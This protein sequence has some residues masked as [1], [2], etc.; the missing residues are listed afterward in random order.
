LCLGGSVP[1]AFSLVRTER[2]GRFNLRQIVENPMA[3][4]ARSGQLQRF[5]GFEVDPRS[6][7]LRRNGIRVRMQDQPLEVLLLLLERRGEVVTREELKQRLWASGT[8]VDSDDGLNTAIRKLR[9]VL[10][11]SAEKPVYIETIPRRGYRFS[12]LSEEKPPKSSTE[13]VE[14]AASI[15]VSHPT[16][17]E[18]RSP[19]RGWR[20]IYTGTAVAMVLLLACAGLFYWQTRIRSNVVPIHIQSIAVLPLANLSNDPEQE[21][22]ADGMTE[23]LITN[24]AQLKSIRVISRTSAMH[25]KRTGETLPQIA[26]ELHVDAIIE[27]TVQHSGDRV[28]VTAK[29]IPAQTDAPM[30]ARVYERDSRD[31]LMMQRELAEAI[32]TQIETRITPQEQ[33]HL[34]S[35]RAISPEAYN[36]YLLGNY[37]SRKR[38]TAA[39]DK[40][41]GHFQE[42]IR[43]DPNYAQAYA[44]LA[45][46]Y[47][48]REIWGGIGIGKL[49]D[50]VRTAV[51][52]A[53]ELDDE[54]PEA[55]VLLARIHY[56]YDWDWQG[57][58]AEYKRAIELDPNLADTYSVYA[59]FLQSMGRHSEALAAAHRAV[60][61]DPLSVPAITDEGRILYRMRQY[62]R[63]IANYQRALELDPGFPPALSRIVEA[64]EQE[65]KFDDAMAY[66]R[67]Y[68][69]SA[70]DSRA[71][72]VYL[73]RIY[74][75]TGKR[76][77]AL[78]ILGQ[79]EK[80]GSVSKDERAL[81]GIFCALGDRDRAFAA[82][83]RGVRTR[84]MLPLAFVDP[85]LDPLRDD[86]RF[87]AM[88]AQVG[89]PVVP[90]R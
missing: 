43:I 77:D 32:A 54:L 2:V 61:L 48:E 29:L 62:D 90:S 86:P 81:A 52:K 60:E 19:R 41:I 64:Y 42:A 24:L 80:D 47:F 44:G 65:K 17:V 30:W 21:Y 51:L 70:G 11:D 72:L 63:A 16:P 1:E 75:Q 39:I 73:A 55:H 85:T 20:P 38:S 57:A 36:A 8:F 7:E 49:A 14:T 53:L 5:D 68:Q 37:M 82:L 50:Q 23:T 26:R 56:Q 59:F 6:R 18:T 13:P 71:G 66:L 76:R 78:A 83:D 45:N 67:K 46:A 84:S 69:T 88:M 40:A 10:G 34:S 74:A 15:A 28:Q 27:G 87:K 3:T 22:F 58:E 25:Y 31:V 35:P 9:E 4:S 12:C 79:I 89:I 33:K